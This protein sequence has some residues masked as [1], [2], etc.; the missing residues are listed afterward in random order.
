MYDVKQERAEFEGIVSRFIH[1]DGIAN[2]ME[3]LD[4]TDF[5]EAP[6]STRYHDACEGGLV[7]HSL[8]VFNYLVNLDYWFGTECSEESIA[9]VA[10]FHDLCKVDSYKRDFR[11]VKDERGVWHRVPCYKFDEDYHFGGHGSKSMYLVQN[12]IALTPEEAAAINCH[13]GQF[14]ATT[15]S[16]PSPVYSSNKLAWMLHVADEASTF[17][18][19]E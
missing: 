3:W 19:G 6:A 18:N 15:Y 13:M 7:H 11:N 4:G 16:N 14:D 10:L 8:E 9:I 12:F 5:Y 2:L 1:R 17:M